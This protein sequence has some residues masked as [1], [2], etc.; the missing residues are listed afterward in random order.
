MILY[1]HFWI[2]I[3]HSYYQHILFSIEALAAVS[4]FMTVLNIH[5]DKR[6]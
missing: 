1:L 3:D 5:L 2:I 4:L 6:C